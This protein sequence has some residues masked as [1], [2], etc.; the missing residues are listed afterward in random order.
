M[1]IAPRTDRPLGGF[2][3]RLLGVQPDIAEEGEDVL[4]R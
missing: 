1:L 4:S 2:C 3:S